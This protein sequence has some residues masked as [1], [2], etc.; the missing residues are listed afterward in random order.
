MYKIDNEDKYFAFVHYFNKREGWKK[1]DAVWPTINNGKSGVDGDGPL[2]SSAIS[3]SRPADNKKAKAGRNGVSSLA[4]IHASIEK[5][6]TPFSSLNN[7]R[8]MKGLKEYYVEGHV[9]EARCEVMARERNK[10]EATKFESQDGMI[11]SMNEEPY[12]A[13]Q[14]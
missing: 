4:R 14:I 5:M 7:K 12:V 11:K 9:R 1:W 13:L 2:A 6:T 10:V 3:T 8:G